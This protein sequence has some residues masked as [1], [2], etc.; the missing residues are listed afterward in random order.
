[1]SSVTAIA[2]VTTIATVTTVTTV[3]TIAKALAG[4]LDGSL[5]FLHGGIVSRGASK[6]AATLLYSSNM[7]LPEFHC[8]ARILDAGVAD[9]VG[10]NGLAQD[11]LHHRTQTDLV[12]GRESLPS[13]LL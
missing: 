7:N 6:V 11:P 12:L 5:A 9:S 10:L 3:T 4:W 13:Q 8:G 1:M 2:A